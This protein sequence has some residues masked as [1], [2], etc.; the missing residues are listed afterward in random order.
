MKINASEIRV[1]MLLE[2]KDDL[3]I[4]LKTQHVKPG[5]G[6]AF[7][8]VEMKSVKKNTK[9][10]ERFRSSETVEK[11]SLEEISYNYL[12]VD[13]QNYFF[14]NPKSFEQIEI[15]KDIIGDKGKLLT[16][17]L[18]V[19]VSFYN[20]SPIS[21]ELP[22]Q[23]TCKIKDTDVALKGQTVSSS[24]KP[25]ILENGLNVQVPPFIES[26]DEIVL[27]TRNLEYVKKI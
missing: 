27:D 3:W 15:K 12:Y 17:N 13:D 25:A 1:G 16:E 24:Y 26:G 6:G 23:V 18:E 5:K 7:A 20:E 10:N 8:Q 21:V 19:K 4:I 9:L 14:I 22:K 11:A 2:Y